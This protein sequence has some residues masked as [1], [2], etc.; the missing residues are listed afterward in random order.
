MQVTSK[1][2]RMLSTEL[3]GSSEDTTRGMTPRVS[4]TPLVSELPLE[5]AMII[6]KSIFS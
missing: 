6:S 3:D 2:L 5:R 1:A 4:H